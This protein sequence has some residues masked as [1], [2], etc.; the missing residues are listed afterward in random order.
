MVR[1]SGSS[2]WEQSLSGATESR[3]QV[4]L[5]PPG[6]AP[7]P[8]RVGG[9]SVSTGTLCQTVRPVAY[10]V[11]VGSAEESPVSQAPVAAPPISPSP[12][13]T[14]AAAEAARHRCRPDGTGRSRVVVS[15]GVSG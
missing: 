4:R 12:S 10:G 3:I 5:V 8:L 11:R 13:T 15:T 9:K 1:S 7:V 2:P 6:P 14:Q